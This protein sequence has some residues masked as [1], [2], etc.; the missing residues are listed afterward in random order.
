VSTAGERP[1][2]LV[3]EYVTGGGWP[4]AEPPRF[5]GE[6]D[7]MLRAVLEDFREWGRFTVVTTRDRRVG[8][9]ALPADRVVWLDGG[10]RAVADRVAD[11]PGDPAAGGRPGY[12]AA[13]LEA[14]AGCEA[15]LVIAPETG[16]A[17]ERTCTWLHGAGLSLLGST[18]A[19]IAVAADKWECSRRFLGAGL[20]APETVCVAPRDAAAAARRLGLPVVFKP[21]D[22][23]GC[24]GVAVVGAEAELRPALTLPALAGAETILVQRWVAG[25]AASVSLLVAGERV[26]PLSLNS[27]ELRLGIPCAYEG[28]EAGIDHARRDEAFDL[29]ARAVG[30]V[31]GL[32]GY[33]GVDL[34]LAPEGCFLMEIN[35]RLTTSYVG[36]RRALDFNLAE[37]HWKAC[38]CDTLPTTVRSR[39]AR[40]HGGGQALH[41]DAG[42]EA[43]PAHA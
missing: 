28:G 38:I 29:A 13:L 2:L 6:A 24:D 40:G 14:A 42:G 41:R 37:A 18:P 23:A 35:P 12:R 3:H 30:L 11:A 27:Q 10:E 8:G 43:V 4:A 5:A 15:A 22:G 32:R 19:A 20:P 17:L 1:A 31:P 21:L 26:L 16:G 25:E 36:L 7:A 9:A 34:V 39:A 33:V